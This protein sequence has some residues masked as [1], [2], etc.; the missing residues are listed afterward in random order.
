[1]ARTRAAKLETR[2]ARLKLPVVK[3]PLFVKVGPRVGLGYRR[4]QTAGTWVVRVADGNGGNWTKAFATADDIGEADGNTI[5]DFW[6]AQDRAR[7][8]A[9]ASRPG[10]DDG[11][12][13]TVGRALDRYKA[14][15]ET[16]G[17]DISNV[18]RVRLH[19][20]DAL[21]NKNVALLAAR[22]LRKWRDGLAKH[23]A[24]ATVEPRTTTALKA[25]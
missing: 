11:K 15:L 19:L 23:V 16:R 1:M 14:D 7:A 17:G 2:T 18:A 12:P 4:T 3:K 13:V 5:L 9:R 25:A 21:A 24:P 20:P 22:D 10:E 8:I 6:Q